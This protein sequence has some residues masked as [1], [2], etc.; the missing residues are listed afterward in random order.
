[1]YARLS[2]SRKR[3]MA[4]W[5]TGITYAALPPDKGRDLKQIHFIL[6]A[7]KIVVRFFLVGR[8]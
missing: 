2:V 4:V 7:L 5:R 6:K 8:E 3:V 1:M